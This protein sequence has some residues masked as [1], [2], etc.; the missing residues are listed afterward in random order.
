MSSYV[1]R[2]MEKLIFQEIYTVLLENTSVELNTLAV[3]YTGKLL[4]FIAQ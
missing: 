2:S 1:P 3:G 4:S